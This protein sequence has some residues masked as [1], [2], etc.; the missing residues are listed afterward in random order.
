MADPCATAAASRE[1]LDFIFESSVTIFEAALELI[2]VRTHRARFAR[3]NLLF[4]QQPPRSHRL[5]LGESQTRSNSVPSCL[6]VTPAESRKALLIGCE[7]ELVGGSCSPHSSLGIRPLHAS[8][9]AM[10][11]S[12]LR[13]CSALAPRVDLP[14]RPT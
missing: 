4:H 12:L 14:S 5:V 11:T 13:A 1:N 10:T 3:L 7:L 8:G 2:E 6:P 9:G